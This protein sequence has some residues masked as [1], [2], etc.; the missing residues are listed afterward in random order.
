L[1][2]LAFVSIV[3]RHSAR[4]SALRQA[5]LPSWL[6]GRTKGNLSAGQDNTVA[7]Y[8]WRDALLSSAPVGHQHASAGE[9][10]ARHD[11]R[12]TFHL[13]CHSLVS[14]GGS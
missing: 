11:T 7:G 14:C 8:G 13:T 1:P 6:T 2:M 9:S 5:A 10:A 4:L 3:L 12:A